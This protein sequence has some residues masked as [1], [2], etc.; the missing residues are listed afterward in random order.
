MKF[1][2]N[3][4]KQNNKSPQIAFLYSINNNIVECLCFLS[5]QFLMFKWVNKIYF[6]M[7]RVKI[8]SCEISFKAVSKNACV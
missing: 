8:L 4:S 6:E 2:K 5:I 1:K 3:H 7:L